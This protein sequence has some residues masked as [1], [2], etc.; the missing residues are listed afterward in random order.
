M[1]FSHQTHSEALNQI[2]ME[3]G[4]L[5]GKVFIHDMH[6]LT[7]THIWMQKAY[8]KPDITQMKEK[9]M[10]S[11]YLCGWEE[12]RDQPHSLICISYVSMNLGNIDFDG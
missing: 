3:M 1:N 12:E 2:S 4:F 7:M 5:L 11:Q 6:M 10:H 9:K 8:T